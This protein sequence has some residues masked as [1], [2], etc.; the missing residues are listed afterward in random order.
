MKAWDEKSK[1]WEVIS[2]ASVP[3]A[4]GELWIGLKILEAKEIGNFC[5]NNS[6]SIG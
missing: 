3:L 4:R 1:R 5:I 6:Q 2:Q